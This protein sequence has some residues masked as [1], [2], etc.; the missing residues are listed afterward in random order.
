MQFL[1][2]GN[3]NF[4]FLSAN[5]GRVR[6]IKELN[7]SKHDYIFAHADEAVKLTRARC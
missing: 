4:D 3:I 7:L 6:V 2:Y 1:K 5:I